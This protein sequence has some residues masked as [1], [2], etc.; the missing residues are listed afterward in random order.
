MVRARGRLHC[1]SNRQNKSSEQSLNPVRL[2]CVECFFAG[3]KYTIWIRFLVVLAG[4]E[5]GTVGFH[6]ASY[7]VSAELLGPFDD[8][9][10]V[11]SHFRPS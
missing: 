9:V 1:H 7:T 8:K 6:Y 10:K 5:K 2:A 11:K 4:L 3:K